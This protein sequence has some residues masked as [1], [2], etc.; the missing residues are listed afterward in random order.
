M[1]REEV[2]RLWERFINLKPTG[3]VE[4]MRLVSNVAYALLELSEYMD[5]FCREDVEVA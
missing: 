3:S 4:I 1:D 2:E 5:A